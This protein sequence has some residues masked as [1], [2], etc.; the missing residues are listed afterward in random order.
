MNDNFQALIPAIK[1]RLQEECLRET[2][3]DTDE[4]TALP[5]PYIIPGK[6]KPEA[7]YY[8]DSYFIN[9]GL[10]R[11]N[12][13]DVARKGVDNL[14]YQV[15]KYG[16]VPAS[17]RREAS[18]Y[19]HPPFLPW[20]VRDVYRATGD[21]EWLRRVLPEVVQEF[22][23]WINKPHTTPSGLHRFHPAKESK[24]VDP[25]QA[26]RMESGWLESP[27]FNDPREFNAIDLNALL[28]RNARMI[29]DLQIEADGAGDETL[30]QKA[31][32]LKKSLDLCW[33]QD[34]G[35]YF[36]YRHTTGRRS[37]IRSL[38]GFM[39]L[40]TELVD[41]TRAQALQEHL[42]EFLAPGG[43]Y[44]TAAD[45][46]QE[47][48]LWSAPIGQAP[49]LYTT[50]K[51]LCD[52]DLM[53]DAADIGINWLSMVK[54]VYEKTG[55]MWAWYNVENRSEIHPDGVANA[56]LLGWTAGIYVAII[57]ELGLE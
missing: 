3:D 56:P 15:R 47:K 43:L 13:G 21:K 28:Q 6:G 19:S 53:E 51:G 36:D 54:A 5:N 55:E 25:V 39:P 18:S 50:L 41:E 24:S 23:F 52:Y 9:L 33:D 27:R 26:A 22:K 44:C 37:A 14:V 1:L 17:N 45:Q 8:W 30:L 29:Y 48:S 34:L 31:A 35:F 16:Y 38:A 49:Y 12:L 2:P 11:L 57:D 20:M 32:H 10:L 42:Q 40:F 46:R 7:M 4:L